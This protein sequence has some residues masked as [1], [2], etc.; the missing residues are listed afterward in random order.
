M[1]FVLSPP[2]YY[3]EY[4]GLNSKKSPSTSVGARVD[5]VRLGGPLWSPVGGDAA[6]A[7]ISRRFEATHSGRP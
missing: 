6:R 3:H 7:L 1:D 4:E 2:V 5:E